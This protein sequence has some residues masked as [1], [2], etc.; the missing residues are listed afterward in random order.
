[1]G[2]QYVGSWHPTTKEHIEKE[3][4]QLFQEYPQARI[5]LNCPQSQYE[6]L[7]A[8][9]WDGPVHKTPLQPLDAYHI[10]PLI[11]KIYWLFEESKKKQQEQSSIPWYEREQK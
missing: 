4:A 9:V 11:K 6:A 10:D 2:I 3:L 5:T 8:I 7:T 1:M